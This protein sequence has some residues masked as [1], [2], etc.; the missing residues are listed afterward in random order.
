MH[1]I[2]T[3]A[4]AMVLSTDSLVVGAGYGSRGVRVPPVA[5]V[6]TGA[7]SWLLLLAA[8]SGGR[9]LGMFLQP[10]VARWAGAA[11]LIVLGLWQ[12]RARPQAPRD[13]AHLSPGWRETFNV[14]KYP[15]AADLDGSG[16]IG[17]WEAVMLGIALG[18]DAVAAGLGAGLTGSPLWLLPAL[19][20]ACGVL[21]FSVGMT[22][23]RRTA[24]HARAPVRFLPGILL[25]TIGLLRLR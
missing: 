10:G 11:V 8:I 6:L 14:I 17:I 3:I 7:T 24:A 13:S 20:G 21:F 19:T 22:A 16:S 4:L 5:L 18:M 9:Y 25:I 12:L 2:T 23:G 15:Q 1:L